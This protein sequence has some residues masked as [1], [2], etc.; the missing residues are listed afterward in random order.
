MDILDPIFQDVDKAREHL[1]KT[2][3]PDG[4]VCPHCGTIDNATKLK[5][6]A[7][8]PGTYQCNEKACRK[9]FSATVGTVFERSRIPLN[10]WLLA[11]HLM[12]ASKTGVSAHQ[13]HR[14]LGVTYK[15][16]WFMCHRLRK[17]MEDTTSGPLG[18]SG[19]EVQADETYYGNSSKRA[20]GYKKGHSHKRK[21]VSLVE[22]GGRSRSVHVTRLTADNVRD[23]LV[24]NA[25]RKSRLV[26][27]ESRLYTRVGKEFD[28][29]KR[30]Y[31]HAGRYVTRDGFTTNNVENFFGV[32]KHSMRG[33]YIHCSEWHLQAY[34]NQFDFLYSNRKISDFERTDVLLRQAEGKRLTYRRPD[35]TAN[36]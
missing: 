10:K 2:R 31:H 20:K 26:T 32:F 14:M 30:V 1:E 22:P 25:D 36:A 35:E 23:V 12:A 4:P 9:Q 33:T 8:R 13:L 5:G 15:S 34:L 21:I 28:D 19:G 18:G 16:A 24:T 3:W 17:A 7:H 29:H 6:K 11:A 27:D